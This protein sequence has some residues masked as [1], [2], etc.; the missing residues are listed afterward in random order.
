MPRVGLEAVGLRSREPDVACM[1][2]LTILSVL[3]A[4]L[5]LG[6]VPAGVLIV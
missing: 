1:C 3:A 6:D 4:V 2:K 5:R